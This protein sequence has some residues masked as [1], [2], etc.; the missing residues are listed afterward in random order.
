MKTFKFTAELLNDML[1]ML[2][3]W[4]GEPEA[5]Q[6][7]VLVRCYNVPACAIDLVMKIHAYELATGTELE[8][9]NK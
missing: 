8:F 9:T 5:E 7:K 1:T 6:R 4:D 2:A 3:C